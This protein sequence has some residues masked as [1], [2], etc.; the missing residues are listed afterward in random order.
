MSIY[1]RKVNKNVRYDN[2]R[3]D[4]GDSEVKTFK[5]SKTC[6]K[7]SRF[8]LLLLICVKMFV[9]SVRSFSI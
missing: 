5:C 1:K 7:I 9:Y 4:L 8:E 2:T 6:R 3:I